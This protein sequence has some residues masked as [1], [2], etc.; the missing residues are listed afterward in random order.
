[1]Q[2]KRPE[3][4]FC[5]LSILLGGV[6][7]LGFIVRQ[8]SRSNSADGQASPSIDGQA[9]LLPKLLVLYK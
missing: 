1:M 7:V 2:R 5:H 4:K 3:Q 6:K 8:Y 9:Q